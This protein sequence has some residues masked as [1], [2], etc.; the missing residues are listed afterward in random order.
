MRNRLV[1]IGAGG[2]G[3]VIADIA[4][5]NGYLDIFFA[6]DNAVGTNMGFPIICTSADVEQQDN[7]KTDFIIAI[8]D[9]RIRKKIAER[10]QLNWA[11]LVHPSAQIGA[12]VKIGSGT[13]VMAGAIINSC[14]QVG[15]HCIINSSSVI[16]H[17]NVVESYAH[18]S[19]KA[20]LGGAVHV[21]ECTHIGIGATVKNNISI[22]N[23]C[24]IGA[25]AVVVDSITESATYIGVPA[26]KLE[27]R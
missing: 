13:V 21:G 4:L 27:S 23:N 26:R 1:V 14:A 12:N 17:D 6:D 18:I 22:C 11:T 19:P 16:E 7:G 10:Y 24:L 9:N 3:R 25:G 20:A 2:H 15:K 8:G 5:K